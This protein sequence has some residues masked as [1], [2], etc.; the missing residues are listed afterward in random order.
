MGGYQDHKAMTAF[1]KRLIREIFDRYG[2]KICGF[3]FDQCGPDREVCDFVRECNPNAVVFINTGV[4]ANETQHEN[5]DF[6]VSEYYGSIESCDSDTLPVHYSQVNRQIGNW[7]AAGGKAPTDAPNLYRYTVRTIAV[8]GQYNCGIA[9]S[10]GPYI[11]QTWEE[12]VRQLLTDLGALLRGH[13][14]IYGTVPG[15]SYV[16]RP[17]AVL[18]KEMWGVSTE[19]PD[20]KTVYLHIL[21]RPEDGLLRLPEPADGKSFREA[22]YGTEKLSLSHNTEGYTIV[23]P[24]ETDPVDTV[25]RL[26]AE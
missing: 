24:A 20:G 2:D 17:N 21:N 12:G 4:T 10:C 19:A 6:L 14:G 7:W 15:R 8:E 13:E 5:S 11:D 18:T 23:L 1:L 22:W 16:E 3:W 26:L 9:W 25:V